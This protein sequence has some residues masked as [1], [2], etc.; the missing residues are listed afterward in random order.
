MYASQI[1]FPSKVGVINSIEKIQR[2]FTMI[3]YCRIHKV[4]PQN[5]PDYETRCKLFGLNTIR[6]GAIVADLKMFRLIL[7][8]KTPLLPRNYFT[9]S[10]SRNLRSNQTTL[11]IPLCKYTPAY[12]SFFV[13]VSR[14]SKKLPE[15]FYSSKID[16]IRH[17]QLIN[18][19]FS[20]N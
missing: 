7:D 6:V 15:E 18:T 10:N 8:M 16:L 13:R 3:L 1:W 4:S 14:W 2:S 12:H 19:N 20:E 9:F 11:Q 5:A 17:A